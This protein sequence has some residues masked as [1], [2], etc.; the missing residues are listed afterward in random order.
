MQIKVIHC[1]SK[2]DTIAGTEFD[3]YG[4][5]EITIG[6]SSKA[7]ITL[8]A[9][10]VSRL[11]VRI[12]TRDHGF[13]VHNLSKNGATFVRDKRL[14]PFESVHCPESTIQLQVGCIL[15]EVRQLA[16]TKS[17]ENKITT[18]PLLEFRGSNL[19]PQVLIGGVQIHLSP[20]PAR[21]LLYLAIE[22]GVTSSYDELRIQSTTSRENLD[23]HIGPNITQMI[24]YIRN[25]FIRVMESDALIRQRLLKISAITDPSENSNR[26][27]ARKLIANRRGHGY[28]LNINPAQVSI[29]PTL[30]PVAHATSATTPPIDSRI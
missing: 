26:D 7:D 22:A 24:T 29:P 14:N 3:E 17:W 5:D 9:P 12:S 1:A 28:V 20:G 11:H 6:R 2:S 10:T 18:S 4:A 23:E 25:A 19:T 30:S 8:R 27:I 21:L 15:L 13:F 16:T